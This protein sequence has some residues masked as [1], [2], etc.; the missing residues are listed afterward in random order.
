MPA[1]QNKPLDITALRETYKAQALPVHEKWGV[2]LR[3]RF[4]SS[5]ADVYPAPITIAPAVRIRTE[6]MALSL[7]DVLHVAP[8][9]N[10]GLHV[11]HANGSCEVSRRGDLAYVYTV[12]S[13]VT[14]S[15]KG[16]TRTD[17]YG[18]SYTQTSIEVEGTT[19]GK[20]ITIYGVIEAM[21]RP[22]NSRRDSPLR[23]SLLEYNPENPGEPIQ[24]EVWARNQ[25]REVLKK[26]KLKQGDSIEAVLYR[27]T[28]EVAL[29][30]GKTETHTRHNLTAITRVE[31]KGSAKRQKT[32]AES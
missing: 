19:E 29:Q 9:E 5:C 27:H 32:D 11:D 8:T 4:G 17:V 1:E 13:V 7:S 12:P 28:W 18:R 25:A 24:H 21:P 2:G 10:G 23:F 14:M 26:L 3:Y 30:G 20:R 31:R 6:T 16:P 15:D 22:V